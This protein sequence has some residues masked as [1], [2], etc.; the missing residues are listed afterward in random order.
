LKKYPELGF[1]SCGDLLRAK[2]KEPTEEAKAL[3]A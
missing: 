1:F 3:K 2:V